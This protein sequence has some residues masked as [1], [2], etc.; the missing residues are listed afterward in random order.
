MVE[1]HDWWID[2]LIEDPN[3]DIRE[4]G[5]VQRMYTGHAKS[6]LWRDVRSIESVG[7]GHSRYVVKYKYRRLMVS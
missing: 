3:F 6:G 5:T 2:R 7:Q 4:N 1:D